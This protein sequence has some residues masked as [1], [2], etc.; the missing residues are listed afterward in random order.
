MFLKYIDFLSTN[1][2]GKNLVENLDISR[3]YYNLRLIRGETISF[4]S[5]VWFMINLN[6]K[7]KTSKVVNQ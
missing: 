2:D 6:S 4:K 5:F 1:K 7:K 3:V